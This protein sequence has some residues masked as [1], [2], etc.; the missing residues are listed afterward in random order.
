MVNILFVMRTAGY[1]PYHQTTIEHLLERGHRIT[2]LF[3]HESGPI[4]ERGFHEWLGHGHQVIVGSALRRRGFWRRLLFATREMR[5]YA[6]YCRRGPDVMFY[7]NRWR[8]YLPAWLRRRAE[9]HPV[10]RAAFR[11]PVTDRLLGAVE[12]VAPAS[13]HIS[14][15]LRRD[16]PDCVV[17][18]PANLRFDEEIEYVKAAGALGIPSVV[19]VMSWDNLTTKGLLH[20]QPDLLLAWHHGHREEAQTIHRIP[21]SRVVITGSPFFDKWFAIDRPIRSRET[22]CEH[23][24]LD[25]AR[26]YALYLGSSA[27]IARDESWLVAALLRAA[28]HADDQLLTSLQL[29]FKPHPAN[30]RPLPGLDAAGIAVYQRE[31]GR[32]DTMDAL[33]EFRDVL[34]HAAVTIGIN[35]TGMLD[36]VLCD[37][38]CLALAAKK[39]RN[40]QTSTAHFQRMRESKA[41]LVAGSV[42]SAM[43]ALSRILAG[44]DRTA[45]A[46]RR[47]AATYA[48]PR[49]IGADAGQAA[50]IAIELASQRRS[51]TE[52]DRAI[53]ETLDR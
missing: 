50:A 26:P 8:H 4:D 37:R 53:G 49:G 30:L 13:S 28:Q 18:S 32:P 38:P 24:G 40:T 33:S 42:R 45:S 1:F 25:P 20:A 23:I 47:F 7:R 11:A 52:I 44:E 16:R 29:V 12:R 48:R 39:Y 22:T 35:T 43:K 31:R 17:V 5:S 41:L 21:A 51:V 3:D 36:A 2:L 6:S 27:N 34:H 46:R 9:H 15:A 10:I 19:P 14:E